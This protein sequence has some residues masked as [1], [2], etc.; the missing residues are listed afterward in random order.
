MI[1]GRFL[2]DK[3]FIEGIEYREDRCSTKYGKCLGYY[4]CAKKDMLAALICYIRNEDRDSERFFRE[5]SAHTI[6]NPFPCRL[7]TLGEGGFLRE[8]R[9]DPVELL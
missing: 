1:D 2:D 7:C 4:E 8:F 3:C 9:C 5:L 6:D